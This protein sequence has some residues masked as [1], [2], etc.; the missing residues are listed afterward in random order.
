M[1]AYSEMAGGQWRR[2]GHEPR[3]YASGV[4]LATGTP[5]PQGMFTPSGG[6]PSVQAAMMAMPANGPGMDVELVAMAPP[7]SAR[8]PA[9]RAWDAAKS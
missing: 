4:G 9:S 5:S 1:Q 2:S 7:Q 8:R 3:Q 6:M